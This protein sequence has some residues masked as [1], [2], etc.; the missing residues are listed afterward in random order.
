MRA[1]KEI[2]EQVDPNWRGRS[3]LRIGPTLQRMEDAK[4]EPAPRIIRHVMG[5]R[6]FFHLRRKG[7]REGEELFF[8]SKSGREYNFFFF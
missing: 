7:K 8:I 6:G 5:L 1:L 2:M 3:E 4:V